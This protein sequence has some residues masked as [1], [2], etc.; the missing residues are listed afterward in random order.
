MSR[1]SNLAWNGLQTCDAHGAD[2]ERADQ[3]FVGNA[4]F[5]VCCLVDDAL[6]VLVVSVWSVGREPRLGRD[7]ASVSRA[8]IPENHL[9]PSP[10]SERTKGESGRSSQ[11]IVIL[12]EVSAH[13]AAQSRSG[14][15]AHLVPLSFQQK[16]CEFRIFTGPDSRS[17]PSG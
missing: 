9:S 7:Q 1:Y 8:S 13:S 6:N 4:K 10:H 3:D 11:F 12:K 15:P 17:L 2:S 5:A 16:D 14:P